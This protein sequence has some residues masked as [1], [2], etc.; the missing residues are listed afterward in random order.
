METRQEMAQA[1]A[2]EGAIAPASS[3]RPRTPRFRIGWLEAAFIVLVLAALA[4]RLWELDGR[5]MHYDEAIHV[6]FSWKLFKGE[7]YVHSP[8]MHGPFQ[9]EL[10]A[11][12]FKLLGD[13]DH[14]ARLA[15]V[16]FGTALAGLPYYLRRHIGGAGAL[17]TGLMLALSPTLLYFSRFG[18]NDIIMAFWAAS[19]FILMWRYIAS[20]KD[21]YL[22]FTAAALALMFTTKETAYLLAALF[23]GIVFLLALPDLAPWVLGR[24][25]SRHLQSPARFFLL[26]VTLTLP[27]WA[28]MAGLFQ[29]VFGLILTNRQG[30]ENGI[31]GAPQWAEPFVP[32]PILEFPSWLHVLAGVL[33]LA[34]LVRASLRHGAPIPSP[35]PERLREP[36]ADCHGMGGPAAVES[37]DPAHA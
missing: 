19:I 15:Y 31:V 2:R 6:H 25:P 27:Q 35:V 26:L 4:L 18:R 3:A 22:V 32:L 5:T 29:G 14:T 37:R 11:L 16:I 1:Q 8:W 13:N 20:G 33:L 36:L 28:A 24:L 23:G 9:I 7:G 12:V 17:L 34:L 30:V 21:R 10:T